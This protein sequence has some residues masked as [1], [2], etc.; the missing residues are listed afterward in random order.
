MAFTVIGGLVRALVWHL[1]T[2]YPAALS[3]RCALGLHESTPRRLL[4]FWAAWSLLNAVTPLAALWSAAPLGREVQLIALLWLLAPGT[5]GAE[6]VLECALRHVVR[7]P[8]IAHACHTTDVALT[9]PVLA[10]AVQVIRHAALGVA[11]AVFPLVL[12]GG[13]TVI[14]RTA[15]NVYST[16]LAACSWARR[17]RAAA[18][19]AWAA[20]AAATTDSETTTTREIT[21][22]STTVVPPLPSSSSSKPPRAPRGA[23]KTG[24]AATTTTLSSVERGTGV[25]DAAR[26]EQL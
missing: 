17:M 15:D 3:V 23:R 5:R 7:V 19:A 24:A 13:G 18:D 22:L 9:S 8:A 20:A 10:S 11:A 6:R 4:I 14:C 16:W 2:L 1:S 12:A 21:T 26:E 25:L